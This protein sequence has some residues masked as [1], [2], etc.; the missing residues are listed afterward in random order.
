MSK[1][2]TECACRITTNA[3]RE[4]VDHLVILTSSQDSDAVRRAVGTTMPEGSTST[5][6]VWVAPDGQ[7]VS[8]KRYGDAPPNYT[9]RV[10]L[11][12]CNGGRGLSRM[13]VSNVERWYGGSPSPL[14]FVGA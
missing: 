4:G 3:M 7:R 8:V 14:P 2:A 13:E 6:S 5:G 11:D 12:I 1:I 9:H 10:T